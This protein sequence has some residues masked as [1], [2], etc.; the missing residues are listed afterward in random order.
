MLE[1]SHLPQNDTGPQQPARADTHGLM[2]LRSES[3]QQPLPDSTQAQPLQ[4]WDQDVYWFARSAL[5]STLSFQPLNELA[6]TF[7]FPGPTD[8][9]TWQGMI[10]AIDR[11]RDDGLLEVTLNVQTNTLGSSISGLLAFYGN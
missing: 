6:E 9:D 5:D 2:P 11:Q 7:S 8:L 3:I 4:P 10:N 1:K